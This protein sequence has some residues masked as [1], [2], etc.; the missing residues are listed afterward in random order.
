MGGLLGMEEES[1]RLST[2]LNPLKIYSKK[3][4]QHGSH[5]HPGVSVSAVGWEEVLPF[6]RF[7]LL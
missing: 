1:R 6:M 2:Y 4:V 7:S 3:N 5:L